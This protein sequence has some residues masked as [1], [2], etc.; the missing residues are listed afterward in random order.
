MRTATKWAA[1]ALAALAFAAGCSD[2]G[3]SRELTGP[4]QSLEAAGARTVIVSPHSGQVQAWNL[5]NWGDRFDVDRP[6]DSARPEDK[7]WIDSQYEEALITA[8]KDEESQALRLV[9]EWKRAYNPDTTGST[10]PAVATSPAPPAAQSPAVASTPPLPLRAPNGQPPA[11][12]ATPSAPA[13]GT[14]VGDQQQTEYGTQSTGA[15]V[16]PA[17]QLPSD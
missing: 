1:G 7:A 9:D 17:P 3:R 13:F 11:K 10:P 5:I 15:K 14:K 4:R 8:S 12:L 2:S 16:P 6:L